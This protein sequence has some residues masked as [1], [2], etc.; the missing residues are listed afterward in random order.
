MKWLITGIDGFAGSHFYKLILEK[1]YEVYGTSRRKETIDH[2]NLLFLELKDRKRIKEIIKRIRPDYLALIAGFSSVRGSFKKEK[3]CMEITYESSKLFLETIREQKLNTKVLLIS[4]ALVYCTTKEKIKEGFKTC[5]SSPYTNAKLKQEGLIKEFPDIK[6]IC[7]RSFNHTGI[8]QTV[9]FIVPKLVKSFVE[10]KKEVRL[11]LG[12]ISS[13]RDFLDVRDVCLAYQS[14]LEEAKE[15]EIYNV[16]SSKCW[17][18]REIIQILEDYSGKK[19]IIQ[20]NKDM[21]KKNENKKMLGDNTKIIKGTSWRNKIDFKST[22]LKMYD[23][24]RD[25]RSKQ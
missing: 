16:C 10:S 19:A 11:D 8:G 20:I 21:I 4:S 17:S 7:S 2:S 12:D 25:N 6:I 22:I 9:E 23:F 24:Y 15:H 14:L 18:I 3:E 1:G 5:N 13:E